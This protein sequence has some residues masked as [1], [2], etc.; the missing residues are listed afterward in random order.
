MLSDQIIEHG[1]ARDLFPRQPHAFL[2]KIGAAVKFVLAEDFAQVADALLDNLDDIAKVLPYCRL[3]YPLLWIEVAQSHR[4]HF[5]Q[6]PIHVPEFQRRPRRVGYLLEATRDTLDAWNTH[7]CWSIDDPRCPNGTYLS[8][9]LCAVTFDMQLPFPPL[10]DEAIDKTCKR[11]Q[12][13][14]SEEWVRAKPDTKRD[15]ACATQVVTP[16]FQISLPGEVIAGLIPAEVYLQ[17]MY[18]LARADWAGEHA[19]L[20]ST[21]GLLNT[22]NVTETGT[23]T[24][25]VKLNKA[26]VRRGQSPLTAHHVLTISNRVKQRVREPQPGGHGELR[27]HLCRGHFKRR[28]TGIFWWSPFLR[29]S[30]GKGYVSKDYRVA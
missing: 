15:L 27:A 2:R 7:L 18:E 11:Y 16:D 23:V 6:S 19:F 8:V 12:I 28:A 21:L 30:W 20:L 25:S 22:R 17:E 29:G 13:D 3:P 26:R 9:A 14:P 10:N 5:I 1:F 24:P 4:P